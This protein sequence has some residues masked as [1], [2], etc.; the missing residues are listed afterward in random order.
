[1]LTPALALAYAEED[2][3]LAITGKSSKRRRI[4]LAT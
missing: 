1:V 2:R 3:L 4:D